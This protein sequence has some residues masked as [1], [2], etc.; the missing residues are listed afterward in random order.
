MFDWDKLAGRLFGRGGP[1]VR[2][3]DARDLD[4]VL[5]MIRLHDSDDYKAAKASFSQTRLDAPQEVTAHFV[6]IDPE[7]R[8]PVG[9]TG[10]YLDDLEA[11]GLYW[12]GWTYVNPFFRGKG[13]GG[14]LME[15]VLEAVRELRGRK[16]YLSTSSLSNYATAVGFYERYGFVEEGRLLDYYN[17]GEHQLIMGRRLDRPIERRSTSY[18]QRPK[19][20]DSSPTTSRET[21]PQS[22][23]SYAPGTTQG[24]DS[25]SRGKKKEG[26][27]VVFEF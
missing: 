13:Y 6:I 23:D 27:D 5:R 10:Y 24:E 16:I 1:Q 8:R 12:L 21:P 20:E 26:G 7:E 22:D 4:E 11:R 17:D 9:V 15:F 18:K 3:M 14:V 19:T 25:G 2:L